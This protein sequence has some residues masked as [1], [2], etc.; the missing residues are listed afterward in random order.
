MNSSNII[1]FC[2]GIT[3]FFFPFLNFEKAGAHVHILN[4][5][6]D[7]GLDVLSNMMNQG[8]ITFL[9]NTIYFESQAIEEAIKMLKSRRTRGKLV[10]N[11]IEEA[12]LN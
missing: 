1:G 7:N 10:C 9:I 5:E 4:R 2:A 12:Y 6:K 8:K 11:I 3:R